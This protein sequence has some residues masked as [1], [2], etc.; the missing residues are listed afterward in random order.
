[1]KEKKRNF[2]FFESAVAAWNGEMKFWVF[3]E[4]KIFP[5]ACLQEVPGGT[6]VYTLRRRRCGEFS[7]EI[8]KNYRMMYG[9]S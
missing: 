7:D 4:G 1:M 5:V 6:I 2:L 3:Q 8:M 9:G